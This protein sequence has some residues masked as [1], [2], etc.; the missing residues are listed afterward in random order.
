[1]TRFHARAGLLV[2]AVA[3]AAACGGGQGLLAPTTTT[4]TVPPSSSRTTTSAATSTSSTRSSSSTTGGSTTSSAARTGGALKAPDR[5][6]SLQK[7]NFPGSETMASSLN[8][9][10]VKA[11]VIGLYGTDQSTPS[12][13]LVAIQVEGANSATAQLLLDAVVAG[14]A[15]Q[16]QIDKSKLVDKTSGGIP[17]KCAPTKSS[18]VDG[19]FCSWVDGDILGV[20]IT[21]KPGPN[22]IDSAFTLGTQAQKAVKA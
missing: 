22:D 3:L 5:I 8:Q 12:Y 15:G 21:F 18:T 2:A 7:L 1:M 9:P 19:A 16:S 4:T 10:G 13:T 11:A 20:G 17:F 14:I 6:G